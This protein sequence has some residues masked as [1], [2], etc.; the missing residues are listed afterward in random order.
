MPLSL[1]EKLHL[2]RKILT[3]KICFVRL[4]EDKAY[5]LEMDRGTVSVYCHMADN[6]G[7]CGGGGWT[8]VMKIDGNKVS[9]SSRDTSA[10]VSLEMRS[11]T[12]NRVLLCTI[13]I[14][15]HSGY[16]FECFLEKKIPIKKNKL[17]FRI[18]IY[19]F[20]FANGLKPL[21]S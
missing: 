3:R 16:K 2:S 20:N 9:R 10:Y 4:Q 17:I 5:L 19:A 1:A 15:S 13:T 21:G 7:E 8:L 14:N 6:L 18:L 11:N 12:I